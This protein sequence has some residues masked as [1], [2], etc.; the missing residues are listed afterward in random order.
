MYVCA[1]EEL[2]LLTN[3]GECHSECDTPVPRKKNATS[4][5][6]VPVPTEEDVTA[7]TEERLPPSA[8][9]PSRYRY[10]SNRGAS[11]SECDTPFSLQ[12]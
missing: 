3:K 4:E 9:H 11:S 2:V 1:G 8:I 12:Q 6:H 10:S 5:R 7:V